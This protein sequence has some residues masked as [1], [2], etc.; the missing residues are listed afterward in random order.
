MHQKWKYIIANWINC[1]FYEN[2][3]KNEKL[4]KHESLVNIISHLRDN[5]NLDESKSSVFSG[6][7][8]EEFIAE[9]YPGFTF[10]NGTV[11][12]TNEEEIYIAASLLLFFVCVNSKD[13]DIKSA[14]CSKLSTGD[15]EVILRYSKTLMECHSI[16]SHDVIAAIAEACGPDMATGEGACGQSMVAET[17]PALRSL[18]GEVRRLQATLDAERFDKNYLQDELARTNLKMEKLLKDKEQYKMDIMNLKA[19]ISMCCG[20]DTETQR[21]EAKSSEIVKLSKQLQL[22]EQRVVDVQE[23][24]EEV[25]HERD[26]YKTKLDDL[27]G[28]C[29]RL[30][31]LSQEEAS[32]SRHLAEELETEKRQSQTLPVCSEVCANVVEVQLGEERAKCLALK[33]QIQSL[34]DEMKEQIQ[35]AET[36]QKSVTDREN[37]ILN[38]KHRINE[39]IEEKNN[40]KSYFDKE[41]TKLNNLVNELEQK[42]K[43]NVKHSSSVIEKKM[44]DIQTLQEEKLSLLQ[45]LSDETTK[46]ENMIKNLKTEIDSE[47]LS[48]SKMRDDYENLVMKMKEKV[49][50]RNN[51]LVE[52]QNNILKKSELIEQ[53]N[54]ELRKERE[55]K[56]E[57]INKYNKD[58]ELLHA[59]KS[60]VEKELQGKCKEVTELVKQIHQRDECIEEMVKDLEYFK[61]STS[62]LKEDCRILEENKR[63]LLDDIQ[64]R[65]ISAEKLRIELDTLKQ[66]HNEEKDMLQC[67]F[68]EMCAMVKSLQTQ[69]QNEIDFKLGIQRELEKTQGVITKLSN[70]NTKLH[71]EQAEVMS[72]MLEK[73]EIIKTN[74]TTIHEKEELLSKLQ[75]DYYVLKTDTERLSIELLHKV[76]LIEDY[77][78]KLEHLNKSFE[79]QKSEYCKIIDTLN[80]ELATVNDQKQTLADSSKSLSDENSLVIKKFNE[81]CDIITQM[82]IERENLSQKMEEKGAIIQTLERKLND[83]MVAFM[84]IENNFEHEISKLVSKLSDT[85]KTLK[86][87]TIHSNKVIENQ[88][89][90]IQSLKAEI[91]KLKGIIETSFKEKAKLESEKAC[92]ENKIEETMVKINEIENDYKSKCDTLEGRLDDLK[93]EV[94]DRDEEVSH[95]NAK[96]SLLFSSLSEKEKELSILQDE[97]CEWKSIKDIMDETLKKE[98]QS[99]Q[100]SLFKLNN[101]NSKL[102]EELKQN[103]QTIEI[104]EEKLKTSNSSI[105]SLEA[106]KELTQ[107]L[108]KQRAAVLQNQKEIECKEITISELKS[109]VS[110]IENVTKEMEV[111]KKDNEQ[112]IE[113]LRRKEQ[114]C[115]LIQIENDEWKIKKDALEVEFENEKK[116]L[117]QALKMQIENNQKLET[118][119]QVQV[120][121]ALELREKLQAHDIMIGKLQSEKVTQEKQLKDLENKIALY[122][123]QKDSLTKEN[124]TLTNEQNDTM[125]KFKKLQNELDFIKNEKVIQL[126]EEN[127]R[128]SNTLE[129]NKSMIP[130]LEKLIKKELEQNELLRKEN[131]AEKSE[132]IQKCNILQENQ[133]SVEQEL[134]QRRAEIKAL[135]DE[136]LNIKSEAASREEDLKAQN[137][138]LTNVIQE[139]EEL[140]SK[141]NDELSKEILLNGQYQ[142]EAESREKHIRGL[143]NILKEDKHA[144]VEVLMNEN[145]KLIAQ[146]ESNA[147]LNK[148]K[149]SGE[150]DGR[151]EKI[152][153]DLHPQVDCIS[154]TNVSYPTMDCNKTI[155]D[156]EKI[157][158]DKNRTITFLQVEITFLKSLMAESENK[159]LDL[160]KNLEV[161]QENC[162]QLSIDLKKI[163]QQKNEEIADLKS[164]ISKMTAME[165]RASQIIKVS[166]KYQE[167]IH[168]RMAE[169]KSNTVLKELT[170]FGNVANCDGDLK[171]GLNSGAVTMEDLESFLETTERHI[172]RC[173]EKRA[174]LQKERDRLLEVNRINESEIISVRKFL[175]ELSV[176]VRTFSSVKEVYAQQL[177]RVVSLQRTVRREILE[178][179][180]RLTEAAACGLERG[181]AA[182]MQDL[183]ECAMNLQRWADRCHGRALS[184]ERIKQAFSGGQELE[185]GSLAA[186][187]FQNAG[188][189]AQMEQLAGSFQKLLE[190]AA[191][192]RSGNGARDALAM[193]VREVRAEYEEKLA[194]MKT[195]MKELYQKEVQSFKEAQRDEIK[196]LHQ[197][198]QSTKET[199]KQARK[200]YEDE[201]R[202]L[203]LELWTLGEKF[204][205]KNDEA[206]WLRRKQRSES[207]MSLQHVPTAAFATQTEEPCK[208]TDSHSLRSLPVNMNKKREGRGLHMSDEEGEVFDNRCLRELN[209]PRAPRLSELRWRNSLCPPHLKSSYP[210]ETQFAPALREE[211]IKAGPTDASVGER[212]QRKEVGITAYKKPGPPTP[213]K[214]AGRLSATDSELRESLRVEAEPQPRKTATPSRL[215]LL[216]TSARNDTV[217]GTPRSRRLS[218]FF[219]KK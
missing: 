196:V 54:L 7:S 139:K 113:R 25:Q 219:R 55:L 154:S 15:Q 203:N 75:Q 174:A 182:A 12:V 46:S 215:R 156:L 73:D 210:A 144:M 205:G 218:N 119:A 198:L 159:V 214:Q 3:N 11:E 185:R 117:Q 49:L 180:E 98:K 69:L 108:D 8:L 104:L 61:M 78:D 200:Y 45:S 161:S 142:K 40:L 64:N 68:E 86:E 135:Q 56:D 158:N 162:Q 153:D 74:N 51:E 103:Q 81:K 179:E 148:E 19:K 32:R 2:N 126:T 97:N 211:D 35:I 95:L 125:T 147:V 24:L 190:E 151:A 140:L 21:V 33:Q 60:N 146:I 106:D 143:Q 168:K 111:I 133:R 17:P 192:A 172:R 89:I 128:L 206:E 216:F 141:I 204:L 27:K 44:Q 59:Q 202:S 57:T 26:T 181:Y 14:M 93:L 110:A 132:L 217:E 9:K 70:T 130:T 42:I 157:L 183:A 107:E 65:Q 186:A 149:C 175:A 105:A 85:E 53:L 166:A 96:N 176:S 63:S 170:N 127:T 189:E 123:A 6:R 94:I 83:K 39:E 138:K 1:Y 84:E 99:M 167:I 58:L 121:K 66:M 109:R 212:Q 114:E 145:K 155:R 116:F 36:L 76:K 122:E 171:R 184:A 90:Q 87:V 169:I 79:Q 112:I 101:N 163:L 201:I 209:T 10:E 173:S 22:M 62:T 43:D 129:Q 134:N 164:K 208:G 91:F 136:I 194:R 48:K 18:H 195:K 177:S 213:S 30:L 71:A 160:T 102:M 150:C 16:S 38:L 115:A 199:L 41:I 178:A 34:Q 77:E 52:Q 82:E 37:D 4:V 31:L 29:D 5:F 187:S 152:Q 72:K 80:T 124:S 165:N 13:V 47:K 207:L 137:I 118:D 67:K 100:E 50:N 188:L 23:Q 28:E 92:L 120:Q 20:Q 88:E 197:E 191:R 131:S 193:T